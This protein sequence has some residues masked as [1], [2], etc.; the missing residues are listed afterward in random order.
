MDGLVEVVVL[1]AVAV[2]G[3]ALARRLG[4]LAPILL[5]VGGLA[6]SFVPGFPEVHLEPEMVL[7]GI[8]PTCARSCCSPSGW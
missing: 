2:L 1:V 6:L 8:L 5:V 3:V 4:M 7:V